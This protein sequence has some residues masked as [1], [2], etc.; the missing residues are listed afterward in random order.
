MN[1]YAVRTSN[2]RRTWE[3]IMDFNAHLATLVTSMAILVIPTISFA[4]TIRSYQYHDIST[5]FTINTD[6]TVNVQ[7][8]Q[9]YGFVGEYHLGWRS[10]PHKGVDA[11]T[12]VSVIDDA[13]EQPLTYSST[14]LD[15]NDPASWGKYTVYEQNDATDIE[16]YYDLSKTPES[17]SHTWTLNYTLHGALG[18]YSD[19]DEL[20]WNLFTD[21]SVPV[22]AAEAYVHLPAPA[23]NPTE[24]LYRTS[25][26][27]YSFEALDSQTFRF[28]T[29]SIAPN[30][31][32]T[33]ALGWQK[34]M[35]H[36]AAYW[37]D[38][39]RTFWPIVVGVVLVLVSLVFSLIFWL[40]E[41][42]R[43]RGRGVVIP[44]YTPPQELPPAMAEVA[45]KGHLSNKTWAA[46]VVDLAVRGLISITE[47]RKKVWLLSSTEYTLTRTAKDDSQLRPY[48]RAFLEALFPAGEKVLSLEKLRGNA[49]EA[50]RL[51]TVMQ[52]I[53]KQLYTQ[54]AEETGA[55][56]NPPVRSWYWWRW[57]HAAWVL[58]FMG[59]VFLSGFLPQSISRTGI[60]LGACVAIAVAVCVYVVKVRPELNRQGHLLK[61]EW[62]GFKLFLEIT[63]KNR[64]QN[65]TPD[66]FEKFLP[67]AM[68]FGVEKQWAQK[69]DFFQLPPPQWYHGAGLYVPASGSAAG[70]FSPSSFAAGFSASFASSFASS[71]GGGGAGG[72]GGAG[73]GGGG[74]GG[75]AA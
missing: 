38:A 55:F 5:T 69:F 15:K 68:I 16:W 59:V 65:L 73:G 49:M 27:Q 3:L 30:E 48:E 32:V 33:I 26:G 35:I 63:G 64:L 70:T 52:E 8:K 18:F 53:T 40:W 22:D 47:E 31:A 7:E 19:H 61:E 54:T 46:T 56:V 20:Y 51:N 25:G 4:Q 11:I 29:A 57:F 2:T 9:T 36:Q 17:S 10:I 42:R 66:M 37:L 45:A 1:L 28:A 13:T 62:L 34:G 50:S 43:Y 71:G 74:G 23:I 44:E 14:R 41:E 67:Y 24:K 39:A 12:N 72:S 75:G 58:F 6:T 21:Y 60:F